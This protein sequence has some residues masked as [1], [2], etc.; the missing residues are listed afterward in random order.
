MKILKHFQNAK[1]F[2]A[3]QL[4]TFT[5]ND[6]DISHNCLQNFRGSNSIKTKTDIESFLK[7]FIQQLQSMFPIKS[8]GNVVKI[9]FHKTLLPPRSDTIFHA[10]RPN[11]NRLSLKDESPYESRV[12]ISHSL[13]SFFKLGRMNRSN[14]AWK[15]QPSL[16]W[17]ERTTMHPREA[18]LRTT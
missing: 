3:D 14:R 18:R 6:V 5:S 2:S 7:S 12:H 9:T 16:Y 8:C 15:H 11:S 10:C 1:I 17:A 13:I 4:Q